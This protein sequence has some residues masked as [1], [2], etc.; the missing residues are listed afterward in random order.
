MGI[1]NGKDFLK[2]KERELKNQGR[3][4]KIMDYIKER[5]KIT[6]IVDAIENRRKEKE[7]LLKSKVDFTYIKSQEECDKTKKDLIDSGKIT[8]DEYDPNIHCCIYWKDDYCE[9]V[10]QHRRDVRDWRVVSTENKLIKANI[11]YTNTKTQNVIE[12]P[13]N[14]SKSIIASLKS[15]G[16]KIKFK[17]SNSN[18]WKEIWIGALIKIIKGKDKFYGLEDTIPF[19]KYKDLTLEKILSFDPNYIVWLGENDIIKIKNDIML[20]A[21]DGST[22]K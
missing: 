2:S 1:D 16:G 8:E 22:K 19:G 20:S 12:I 17:Y 6:R 4:N 13:Y 14:S 9:C 21:I 7:E 10:K 18:E 5:E 3:V 11:E 15:K